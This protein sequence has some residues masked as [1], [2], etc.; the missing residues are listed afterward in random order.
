MRM[1]VKSQQRHVIVAQITRFVK[2]TAGSPV[3][4]VALFPV[5]HIPRT[6]MKTIFARWR[7]AFEDVWTLYSSRGY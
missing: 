3:W 4:S 6:F 7:T 2:E 5:V 1:W